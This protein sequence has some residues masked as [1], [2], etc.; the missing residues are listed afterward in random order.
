[1][2]GKP[3]NKSKKEKLQEYLEFLETILKDIPTQIER[4]KIMERIKDI[5]E[6][7]KHKNI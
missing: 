7:I 1:M 6:L 5:K 3:N 2:K 4:E